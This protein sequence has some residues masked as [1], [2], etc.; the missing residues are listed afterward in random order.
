MLSIPQIG[1]DRSSSDLSD[2]P[3][4][5]PG[6]KTPFSTTIPQAI[7]D[8]I[9]KRTAGAQNKMLGDSVWHSTTPR[10][11][12]LTPA[13]A[14]ILARVNGIHSESRGQSS[15]PSSSTH[16]TGAHVPLSSSNDIATSNEDM[17][18]INR[19][20]TI[21]SKPS[22][23]QGQ[24]P[25]P[26]NYSSFQMQGPPRSFNPLPYTH[27]TTADPSSASKIV[28]KFT[29]PTINASS[30]SREITNHNSLIGHAVPS[31]NGSVPAV[32]NQ[33]P[34]HPPDSSSETPTSGKGLGRGRPGIKRG[35]RTS[36]Q[37]RKRENDS[38]SDA[39]KAST[40]PSDEEDSDGSPPQET[41]TKSGR[42]V[43]RPSPFVPPESPQSKKT[44]QDSKPKKKMAAASAKGRDQNVLCE[45]CLRGNGPLGNAIVFC[46]GCNRAWH[47]HC[48]EPRITKDV[49]TNTAKDWFCADCNASNSVP[50]KRKKGRPRKDQSQQME[51]SSLGYAFESMPGKALTAQQQRKYLES[52]TKEQLV[53][54]FLYLAYKNP[55]LPLFPRLEPSSNTSGASKAP[56]PASSNT[57]PSKAMPP[58]AG[59]LTPAV[60]NNQ[61]EEDSD[62]EYI[63][64]E[65]ALLY[66]KAGQ[67]VKLPPESEDLHILLE[68]PESKTFSHFLRPDMRPVM[69]GIRMAGNGIGVYG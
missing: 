9:L 35:P 60:S 68:G 57:T 10:L 44:R 23:S 16:S 13:T 49:V 6:E 2:V 58:P 61:E 37:K 42:Q 52:L 15:Q 45:H 24:T 18:Q 38:D 33:L 22:V 27:S 53:Q 62:D 31:T 50:V 4:S 20:S 21:I 25:V 40:S 55:E 26:R 67:G 59:T 46:D 65:H 36:G 64:D 12:E 8:G 17:S 51:P 3:P 29:K 14:E 1:D 54:Q 32:P 47:Q 39:I 66:P 43:H 5:P 63:Y 7:Q 19:A 11:P 34:L 30:L 28:L 41:Q 48:H 69:T 56:T